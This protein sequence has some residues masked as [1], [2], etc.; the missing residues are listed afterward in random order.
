[1]IFIPLHRGQDAWEL[2]Q[3]LEILFRGAF[4]QE[5]VKWNGF[6]SRPFKDPLKLSE[7]Y[8]EIRRLEI[9][10]PFLPSGY[11]VD[12]QIYSSEE[13]TK[14][15]DYSGLDGFWGDMKPEA[16]LEKLDKFFALIKTCGFLPEELQAV[17]FEL[18]LRIPG[19]ADKEFWQVY[20]PGTDIIN[21]MNR[22]SIEDMQNY[23]KK[24]ITACICFNGEKNS[25]THPVVKKMCEYVSKNYR[26]DMSLKTLSWQFNLSASYMGQLF[27][28]ETGCLFTDYL[29]DFRIE[30]AKSLLAEGIHKQYSIADMVGFRNPNY[31]AN[32]FKKKT[33]V[34]PSKYK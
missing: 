28:E 24:I 16:C 2:H 5:G 29:C 8:Q 6:I 23:F 33:G 14:K 31:F 11:I 32:V 30:K 25:F 3:K 27:K 18:L 13:I 10:C 26:D 22:P 17:F 34:Y 21:N 19:T 1:V 4:F 12:N 7:C 9:W 20:K 15:I